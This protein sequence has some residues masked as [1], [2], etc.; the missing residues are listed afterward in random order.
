MKFGPGV[1]ALVLASLVATA[2]CAAPLHA[3]QIVDL[4]AEWA[5]YWNAKNLDAIMK[6]YAPEPVFLPTSGER[7]EGKAA[8]RRNF[9]AG[10]AQYDPNLTMKSVT[11]GVSGNLGYDSGTYD[12]TVAPVKGGKAIRA[13]GNYLFLFQRQPN[14]RWKILEQTWT[15]YDPSKL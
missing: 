8:I 15:E 13:K 12:E 4:G 14:G 3:T 7:W 6:L 9:A 11:A 5:G 10:L 1:F 2:V